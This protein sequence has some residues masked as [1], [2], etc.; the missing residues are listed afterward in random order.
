LSFATSLNEVYA[1]FLTMFFDSIT[2]ACLMIIGILGM[3]T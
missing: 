2:N 3:L 1:K